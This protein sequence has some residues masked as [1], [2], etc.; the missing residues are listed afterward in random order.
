[1]NIGLIITIVY[2]AT[3]ALGVLFAVIGFFKGLWKTTI[4]MVMQ[5]IFFVVII[6]LSPSLAKVIGNIDLTKLGI[7][8]T[9]TLFNTTIT[10]TSVRETLCQILTAS[11]VI[12]PLQGQSIY[13]AAL[14]ATDSII[15]L[16]LYIVLGILSV[17]LSWLLGLLFY[18]TIF[19]WFIPKKV[20]TKHK[21]KVGGLIAGGVMGLFATTLLISPL[22]SLAKFIKTNQEAI[23]KVGEKYNLNNN[24]A[25]S[26]VK[27]FGNSIYS[28]GWLVD[29]WMLTNATNVSFNDSNFSFNDITDL[30]SG[31]AGPFGNALNSGNEAD[32]FNYTL[33][34]APDQSINVILDVLIN[35]NLI[36]G[37]MP[38][39]C[40]SAIN[41]A[42]DSTNINLSSLDFSTIDFQGDLATIKAIY[43]NLYS[44]G[45]VTDSLENK[46]ITFTFTQEDKVQVV[47]ALK[48]L[49]NL[50]VIK[51]NLPYLAALSAKSIEQ[52]TGYQLI[53]IDA[54]DYKDIDWSTNLQKI[55]NTIFEIY[56]V[57][58]EDI[59]MSSFS[60]GEETKKKFYEAMENSNNI[61]RL[62]VALCG[63][64]T[65]TGLLD[66]ELLSKN[67][68]NYEAIGQYLFD[69]VPTLQQY[70][71]E[72][73][74]ISFLQSL[75]E[76]TIQDEI[77]V[78]FN[79]VTPLK[80]IS[81]I[82]YEKTGDYSN[83]KIDLSNT[84]QMEQ[85]KQLLQIAKESELVKKILPSTLR[86]AIGSILE[87]AF[88]SSNFMGLTPS[89]FNFDNIDS[90]FTDLTNLID[91][92]PDLMEISELF[93]SGGT[94]TEILSKLDIDQLKTILN[95][96]VNSDVL[97]PTYTNQ[98]GKPVGNDNIASIIGY[99]FSTFDITSYGFSVPER[100]TLRAIQWKQKEGITDTEVDRFC[101]FLS[102]IKNLA[103]NNI[104]SDSG[105][106][107]T[108]MSGDDISSLISSGANSEIFSNSLVNFMDKQFNQKT[109]DFGLTLDFKSVND[110]NKAADSFGKFFD[111]VKPWIVDSDYDFKNL[112]DADYL[113]AILTELY[114]T[115]LANPYLSGEEYID[116]IGD[117]IFYVVNDSSLLDWYDI[118]PDKTMF[119]TI[120][121][122]TGQK[123]DTSNYLHNWDWIEEKSEGNVIVSLE[124]STE[125]IG[126][127]FTLTTKG[128]I[129]N[130]SNFVSAY[131]STDLNIWKGDNPSFD[132]PFDI[133]QNVFILMEESNIFKN[134]LPATL[135]K[136]TQLP[137][138]VN[139]YQLD[140][141]AF[142][143]SYLL[144]YEYS[145]D[146]YATARE[147]DIKLFIELFKY[148]NGGIANQS[149]IQKVLDRSNLVK[150]E[151]TSI[152]YTMADGTIV[153]G[154]QFFTTLM[155]KV[156]NNKTIRTIKSDH[157][158]SSSADIFEMVYSTLYLDRLEYGY[159]SDTLTDPVS[160]LEFVYENGSSIPSGI[161]I[162]VGNT[163]SAV[164]ELMRN[165]IDSLTDAELVN[166]YNLLVQ[167]IDAIQGKEI[168]TLFSS[169]NPYPDTINEI[170]TI[171]KNSK[172]FTFQNN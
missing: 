103:S 163:L 111:L 51:Q 165:K 34:M 68:V 101:N 140:N 32:L 172:V 71:V 107:I 88:G 83:I 46:T 6:L 160:G 58:G 112:K 91:I 55:G 86:K 81:D 130:L 67:I 17:I 25:Y 123:W 146:S 49:G 56:D 108:L 100:E 84:E 79:M 145:G 30:I 152:T 170:K 8:Q 4:A 53:S 43:S 104:L 161:K 109:A 15:A 171:L 93:T 135:E 95:V 159:Y 148:S 7:N 14:A 92:A 113:N 119:Y 60:F 164:R 72:S 144:S 62:I 35:S 59:T 94:T 66:T 155:T 2:I 168:N 137:F 70:I 114:E 57:L 73:E 23:D 82:S 19:K 147:D 124:S 149:V 47:E 44:T 38:A 138:Y 116:P 20:R 162:T 37:I 40:A 128:E 18:H 63:D 45:I 158:F 75:T 143:A 16:A 150:W 74:F 157:T 3:I 134:Y 118:S 31:V 126:E 97:N 80:K 154:K 141:S 96:V 127:D 54:N 153:N 9:V 27:D 41:Y 76:E 167:V 77:K 22:S 169:A 39:L 48:N 122:L 105:V 12:S 133:F 5:I 102:S 26:A 13:Q 132:I 28:N 99:V 120:N 50:D 85:M 89:S 52:S 29:E 110:W 90:L 87:T 115:G 139:F 42:A 33:L 151:D 69:T 78:I 106:D 98:Y 65:S 121:P 142:D 136:I 117:F 64:D 129:Y 1:M 11:G 36:V 131:Y 125:I 21:V 10:I 61:N 24:V 166:E 156:A